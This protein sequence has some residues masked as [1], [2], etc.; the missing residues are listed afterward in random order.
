MQFVVL[1]CIFIQ[2]HLPSDLLIAEQRQM[3]VLLL[4]LI[5]A[6][7]F[8]KREGPG[9]FPIQAKAVSGAIGK[10]AFFLTQN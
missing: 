8:S 1:I 7:T 9:W 6:R 4:L 5:S 3:T 10:K 2:V